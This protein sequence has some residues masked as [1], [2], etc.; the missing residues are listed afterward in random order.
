MDTTYSKIPVVELTNNAKADILSKLGYLP[1]DRILVQIRNELSQYELDCVVNELKT[2]CETEYK[3]DTTNFYE[4]YSCVRTGELEPI[5][6]MVNIYHDSYPLLYGFD[7]DDPVV[8]VACYSY[9]FDTDITDWD[10]SLASFVVH[11]D[12]FKPNKNE[13]NM[14]KSPMPNDMCQSILAAVDYMESHLSHNRI[15]QMILEDQSTL[16]AEYRPQL[17][18]NLNII[19]EDL[20]DYGKGVLQDSLDDIWIMY[21]IAKYGV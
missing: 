19:Y 2:L 21:C 6:I 20:D 14:Q 16:T 3:G 8:M 11:Q 17:T 10:Y 1:T 4:I 9:D 15:K 5:G 12:F 13:T 7:D 18:T